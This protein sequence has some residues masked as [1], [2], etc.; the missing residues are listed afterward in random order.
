MS[1][2]INKLSAIKVSKTTA[3]GMHSDGAGLYLQVSKTSTKSWIFRYRRHG[4]LRDMGLGP[5]HAVSLAEA[6]KSAAI[7]KTILLDDRD[8]IEARKQEQIAQRIEASKS[9]SFKSCA[10]SFIAAHEPKWTSEKHIKQ[11]RSTLAT[12]AEPYIGNLPVSQID[13]PLVMKCLEPI[14]YD[15]TPTASRL[16]Y[17]IE[18]ILDWAKIKEHRQGENPARWKGHLDHLLPAPSKVTAVVNHPAL[19]YADIAGF[20]KILGQKDVF[21]AR[22][23]EFTI[24][25][26]LRTFSVIGTRWDEVNFK[27]RVLTIPASRMKTG[28]EHKVPLTDKMLA[29][30][31]TMG[32]VKQNEYVFPSRKTGGHLSTGAMDNLLERMGR[33]DITVHGF[34]STFRD[35]TSEETSFTGDIAEMALAHAI[36]NNSEAAYRRGDLFKKRRKLM[37][38]WEAYCCSSL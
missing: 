35:W 11:W 36:K 12:Y 16:R 8:P 19:P 37:D 29:V 25:T 21:S 1:R 15:K 31:S 13:T 23:L 27:D 9:I 26:G 3:P 34:R 28:R 24:L 33:T 17:R 6:R 10:A 30:I 5:I 38:A 7:Y 32:K 22:L 20:M 14:W 2:S 18:K 4:K